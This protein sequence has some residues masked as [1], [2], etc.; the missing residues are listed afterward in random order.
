MRISATFVTGSDAA[1]NGRDFARDPGDL[2]V[3]YVADEPSV[4]ERGADV[5][6]GRTGQ[7]HVGADQARNAGRATSTS[8]SRV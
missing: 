5:D 4:D 1:R 8:A 6:H 2:V 3:G 7:D